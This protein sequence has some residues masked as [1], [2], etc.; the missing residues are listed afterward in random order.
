V[1]G[2]SISPEYREVL[3][4][5]GKRARE[6]RSGHRY[7]LEKLGLDA[8][9]IRSGLAELFERYRWDDASGSSARSEAQPSEDRT[10]LPHDAANGGDR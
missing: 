10:G 1:L 6:H 2:L 5:E 9:A 4:A 3:L 7:S 8:D